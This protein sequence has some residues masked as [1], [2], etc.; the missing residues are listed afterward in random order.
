MIPQSS[1]L[2]YKLQYIGFIL[3]WRNISVPLITGEEYEYIKE[4]IS[5][6]L[7]EEFP[8]VNLFKSQSSNC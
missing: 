2:L 4:Q 7:E 5:N 1:M 6:K 8:P 3:L